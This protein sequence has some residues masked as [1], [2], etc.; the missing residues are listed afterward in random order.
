MAREYCPTSRKLTD[1]VVTV[2]EREAKQS[3]GGVLW[4]KTESVHCESCGTFIRSADPGAD[5]D[6]Q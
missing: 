5:A 3:D 2:S 1:T 6:D 4:V